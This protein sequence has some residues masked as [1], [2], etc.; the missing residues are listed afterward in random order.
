MVEGVSHT[1]LKERR[2]QPSTTHLR[3]CSRTGEQS[4]SVMDTKPACSA[5]LAFKLGEKARTLLARCRNGGGLQNKI[6]K[7]RMFV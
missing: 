7:F 2:L 1:L 5:R 4:D 3:N 6:E